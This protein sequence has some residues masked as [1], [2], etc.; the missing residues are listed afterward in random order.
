MKIIRRILVVFLM[1]LNMSL[2]SGCYCYKSETTEIYHVKDYLIHENGVEIWATSD[3][4]ENNGFFVS[5]E[6]VYPCEES[7]RVIAI[8]H[9]YENTFDFDD[10]F[11]DL[12]TA[13]L[14]LNKEEFEEYLKEIYGLE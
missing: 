2:L 3:D 5:K 11:T 4:G 8:H 1:L 12:K 7:S 13:Y 10:V 6:N 9:V 14:Y